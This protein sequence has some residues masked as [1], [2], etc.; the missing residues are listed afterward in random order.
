MKQVIVIRKDL[1]LSLGKYIAQAVHAAQR[2]GYPFDYENERMV[3]I[4]VYVK[5]EDKLLKL[6]EQCIV[7]EIPCG[8]QVDAGKSEVVART[9]T[10]L[11]IGP[12]ASEDVDAITGKLQLVRGIVDWG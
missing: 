2:V 3:C 9:L 11:C 5:S 6:H 7:H 12:A 4:V 8:L 1:D 10:S